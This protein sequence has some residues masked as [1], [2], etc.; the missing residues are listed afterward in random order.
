M[1][2]RKKLFLMC[3]S[4]MVK[5][6]V[7]AKAFHVIASHQDILDDSL[8]EPFIFICFMNIA[9]LNLLRQDLSRT[10]L[11]R[12]SSREESTYMLSILTVLVTSLS[13][14]KTEGH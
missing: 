3:H 7:A 4:I 5:I 6:M 8:V 9:C 1:I 11:G 12:R 14:K 2:F 10:K 13:Q